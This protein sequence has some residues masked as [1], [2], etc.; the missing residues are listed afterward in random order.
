[1]PGL[2]RTHPD[3]PFGQSLSVEPDYAFSAP[4]EFGYNEICSDIPLVGDEQ[5]PAAHQPF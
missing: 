2:T 3:T 5:D 1:M 4:K